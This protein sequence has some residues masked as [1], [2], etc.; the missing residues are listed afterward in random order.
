MTQKQNYKF[1]KELGLLSFEEQR[2]FFI[3]ISC[4]TKD[5]MKK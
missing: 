4:V 2:F 3:Y 1:A 5:M